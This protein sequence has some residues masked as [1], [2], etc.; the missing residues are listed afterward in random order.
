MSAE[1]FG[2][3]AAVGAD[4][5]VEQ[6]PIDEHVDQVDE[7]VDEP[8]LDEPAPIDVELPPASSDGFE[9]DMVHEGRLGSALIFAFLAA[10]GVLLAL[11]APPQLVQIA[12]WV[13]AVG[14]GLLAFRQLA[15][16]EAR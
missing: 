4:D 2:T 14:S 7:L 8:V 5:A 6:L 11:F 13:I 15:G 9:L 12:G 16:G 3:A 1:T 10:M